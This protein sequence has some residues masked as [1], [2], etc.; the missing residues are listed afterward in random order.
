MKKYYKIIKYFFAICIALVLGFL[1]L[2]NNKYQNIFFKIYNNTNNAPLLEESIDG[3]NKYNLNNGLNIIAIDLGGPINNRATDSYGDAILL[4]QNGNYL[5]MDTGTSKDTNDVLINFLKSQEINHFDIYISHYHHDH[6]GKTKSILKDSYFTVDN[7]YFPDPSIYIP[8]LDDSKEWYS[9]INPFYEWG[10]K[11]A[12]DLTTL[13]TNVVLIGE[14]TTINIGDATLNVIWDISNS[15]V[16]FNEIYN[17][18]TSESSFKNRT[19]NDTSLVSMITYKGVR[20]LT[21]GDIMI[22]AEQDILEKN[23]DIKADIFKFSHHG[24]RES[25]TD[26]FVN[27][28]NPKYAFLPN[29]YEAGHGTVIWYGDRDNGAYLDLANSLT[30]KTNVLSTLYNGNILYNISTNGEITTDITRNYN[31]LTIK[32]KDID[33]QNEIED[34]NIYYFNDRAEYHLDRLN[35]IKDIKDYIFVN[36]TYIPNQVL[37]EDG[38]IYCYYK[39]RKLSVN[40][41]TEDAT[42]QDVTV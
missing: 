41:S 30:S 31:K 15:N 19:I 9:I 16:D 26:D 5:L 21:A 22:D 40:Y 2:C 1:F 36:S 14:G 8:K 32:Y 33:S 38:T 10:V 20:Y 4:E 39:K 3:Y 23:L 12:N 29:N 35:Y 13:G 11:Y 42:N 37:T 28:V 7:V 6:Y 18:T 25:N 34:E 17:E 24:A 27:K